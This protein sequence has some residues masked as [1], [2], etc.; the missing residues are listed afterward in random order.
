MV[1][2]PVTILFVLFVALQGTA[3]GNEFGNVFNGEAQEASRRASG[4]ALS[5]IIGLLTELRRKEL[6]ES[7]RID[8]A[9]AAG[10]LRSAAGLMDEIKLPSFDGL[11][12]RIMSDP[13][14]NTLLRQYAERY[15]SDPPQSFEEL[16]TLFRSQTSALADTMEKLSGNPSGE[17]LYPD[18]AQQLGRYMELAGVVTDISKHIEDAHR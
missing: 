17:P 18:L 1:R 13:A 11:D 2:Y 10:T 12:V 4:L 5:G 16:F 8:I 6:G 3:R 9:D 15:Q 7:D 14:V